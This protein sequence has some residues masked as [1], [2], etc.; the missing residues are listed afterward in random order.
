MEKRAK[1]AMDHARENGT[2]EFTIQWKKSPTWGNCPRIDWRGEKAAY[3]SGCGYDKES[4]VIQEFVSSL[5]PDTAKNFG[6]AGFNTAMA[7]MAEHGWNLTR[8][9]TG[10][11]EDG[12]RLETQSKPP[13]VYPQTLSR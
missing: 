1:A 10:K 2:L 3:A 5:L 9:Y 11:T 13:S 4:A 6:G 8:T 7:I 12:F